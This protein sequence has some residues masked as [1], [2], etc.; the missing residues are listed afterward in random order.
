MK[1]IIIF[2]PRTR[3]KLIKRRVK[4]YF[5]KKKSFR[6]DFKI[7]FFEDKIGFKRNHIKRQ[8]QGCGVTGPAQ[9]E[10]WAV[11]LIRC[12]NETR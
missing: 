2:V 10:K 5:V 6:K 4:N 9:W 12:G 8:G 11:A 1:R 3:S 7:I